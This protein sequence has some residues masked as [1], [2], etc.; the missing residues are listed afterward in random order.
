MSDSPSSSALAAESDQSTLTDLR[1]RID[2][3][4]VSERRRLRRRLDGTRKIRSNAKRSSVVAEIATA[5]AS[6]EQRLQRRR[7]ALP[8]VDYPEELP[9]SAARTQLLDAI[10]DHQVV[11][12]AGDTGSGKTTQLPKMCLELGRGVLGTVGHTQPR[13]L[14]ARTVANRIA[15]ELGTE[16]GSV[17]G[18]Q[19]RFT[20]QVSDST[21]V[22]VMTDGILLAEIQRDRLLERY[23]TLI[24]DEAHERSLN[25]DF[26]LGYLKQ[27]LPRRPDLKVIITSAT[28]D[29]QR[30]SRHFDDAPVV[31]VSGRTYPVEVRYRPLVEP[32][33]DDE[34]DPVEQ[35]QTQGICAAVDELCAEGPGDILVFLS[36]EREIRDTAEALEKHL[37]MRSAPPEVLPL[38][39]R[40]S[41]AEQRRVFEPH[42]RRRIVLATNVA[43]TS[44][45][46]PGITYVIDPGTARISRYSHRTKVQRLPIEPISQ[47]SANQRKG[48][49]GRVAPGICIRLYSEEDFETR[50]EF[51]D[52]EILRTNLA[53]VIL[54]MAAADLGDVADF[55]FLEPPDRRSITDGIRLLQELGALAGQQRSGPAQLTEVGRKLAQLPMDPRLGRMLL[56]GDEAGC[57]GEVIIITAALSIQDPRERPVAAQ[58]AADEAHARFAEKDSDF[59]AYLNLWS[60]VRQRQGELSG[61]QFRRMCRDEYLNYLRIR[62]WQDVAA[63]LRQLA[64]Q[65]GLTVPRA[66]AAPADPA[67]VHRALLSGLLSHIGLK[68]PDKNEYLGARGA[69]FAIFPGSGLFKRQPR[70]VMAAELV[71]TSR[72]WGRLVARIEPEWVEEQAAHLVKRT[73]AEPHWEKR[74]GAVVAYERVTLFGIPLVSGR[75]VDYGRIDP[76]VSRELFIRHALV[77]GDWETRHQFFHD[78]RRLL[79]EVEELEHRTRRRDLRVD[80]DTL[81]EFYERRIGAEVVS[82]AHFDSWWKRVRRTDPDLLTFPTE[83]LRT[84]EAADVRTEDYPDV[85]P[86]GEVRI[87]LT[88]RFDPAREDDADDTADGV[89]A[90]IPLHQLNQV[91]ADG[92]DW[93]VPGLRLEI[94]TALIRALPKSLRRNLVP[95]PDH[96]AA[97]LARLSPGGEPLSTALGRELSRMSGTRIP[98]D[99][100]D[101]SRVPEHLRMTFRIVDEQGTVRAQ[102]KDLAQLRRE[103]EP[104]TRS[105]L[106][107]AAPGIEREG[108]TDW[109]MDTL[110]RTFERT[111]GGQTV[112]GYPALVPEGD[113][114]RDV[115]DPEGTVAVRVLDTEVAQRQ[116]MWRGTRQLLLRTLASPLPTVVRGLDN[117]TKL[118]LGH[119]PHGGVPRLLNDCLAAAVDTLLGT[120]GGPVWDAAAFGRLRDAVREDLTDTTA[121]I[122]R[123]VGQ[124]LALANSIERTITTTKS[125]A[126][127]P[128]LTDAKSQLSRLVYPGF[129][130]EAGPDRLA[131]L[132][133]YLR[134]LDYRLTRVQ[135][136][137][138]RDQL[139]LATV[140]EL[141]RARNELCQRLS[142]ER[143]AE[144]D[145]VELGWMLEELRVSFFAQH[146]GTAYPVSEKRVRRAMA[147][148]S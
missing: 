63:Q 87:P 51:T 129:V 140:E 130:T 44:L 119:N 34:D 92:F 15:D 95:V 55:P 59:L 79:A 31:E 127:L 21:L 35:D 43:E 122:V 29:P 27:L 103:L 135:E 111:R 12:V 36:G 137:P 85:W 2:A 39:A 133:R 6:A 89:T 113:A 132:L 104:D 64:K 83:L 3:L 97:A 90:H 65:L 47:A 81:F 49:C 84:E 107:A 56:A 108:L 102:G 147:A 76:H 106:A 1:S 123:Q 93:Q 16:L 24:I 61:N 94:V 71:E 42:Q 109:D 77:E 20:E 74:R 131:D 142:P 75:K 17:I 46:V 62:E 54:Q 146:L 41:M 98:E 40:L 37:R 25:I 101:W 120:A 100:W 136:Q 22:K 124:I 4:T 30:F 126:V 52:P 143:R 117:Q 33:K 139:H 53:S 60:H 128:S 48:R 72:L 19:V 96:A 134:A 18:Y 57:L 78:N 70:W 115:P 88:Y 5:V 105:E 9:V 121:T 73:Y 141:H 110:P 28:I 116:E 23:D 8:E 38:Y 112:R 86:Q 114:D 145:V 144:P 80:D 118:A 10:R 91:S 125:M 58:Q 66:D 45:T 82:A 67:R 14:A 7:T 32:A 68:D 50:P 13:R 148:I 69:K 138:R 26:I 11:V 99:S